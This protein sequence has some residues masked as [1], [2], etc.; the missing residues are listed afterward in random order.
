MT[1]STRTRRTR[2][3]P[4][5][6]LHKKSGQARV[7]LNG[8]DHY[9]GPYD[10]NESRQQYNRLI[11][12]YCFGAVMVSTGTANVATGLTIN[13]VVLAYLKHAMA[14]Y[15]KNGKQTDEVN[16]IKS[17]VRPLRELYPELPANEFGQI[18]LKAVRQKMIEPRTKK[19]RGKTIPIQ[20]TRRFINQS[21]G[22]IRRMFKWAVENELVDANVLT[23]LQAVAPLMADRSEARD[24]PPRHPIDQ[25]VID[26]VRELV[27]ERTRDLIDLFLL[28]G[29]RP[30]EL[31]KLTGDMIDRAT[32]KAKGVWVAELKDHKTAHKGKK[33]VLIFNVKAQAI[34]LRHMK[35]DPKK[36]LF[37]INRAS[38]SDGIKRACRELKI[39]IFT[40]HWLRHT[41]ATKVRAAGGLDV[42]Q[43][44]LGHANA[45]MTEL[46]AGLD[47]NAAIEFA[48][49]AG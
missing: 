41:F 48:R 38:V 30:G 20:W 22:R 31:V 7:R 35:P 45:S 4:G 34:L 42:A 43:K 13:E 19:V 9:L 15:V 28:V 36:R 37:E 8:I 14:Y 25:D 39:P 47:L 18:A 21:V 1:V 5:Y 11:A 32:Y 3:L 27:P 40:A 29:C 49:D 44:L 17:A 26:K 46:Y 23:K 33:R 10:S 6:L 2:K 12:E 24:N 16:C